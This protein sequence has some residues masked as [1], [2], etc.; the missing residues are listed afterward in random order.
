MTEGVTYESSTLINGSTVSIPLKT[1]ADATTFSFYPKLRQYY[2]TLV[3]EDVLKFNYVRE[4]LFVSRA[5]GFKTNYTL[6][7]QTSYVHT[8]AATTDKDSIHSS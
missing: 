3:N 4:E 7:P 8:D 5:C 1:D 2:S 6:D